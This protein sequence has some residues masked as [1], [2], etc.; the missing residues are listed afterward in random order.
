[1]QSLR[2]AWPRFVAVAI[3]MPTVVLAQ[4]R[5][6]SSLDANGGGLDTHLLRPALDSRGLLTVNGVDVLPAQGVS[7]GLTLDYGRGLLRLPQGSPSTGIVSDSFTGTFLA[8][9]G[10]GDRAVVGVSAPI[11]GMSGA[12]LD[13]Q[14]VAGVAAHAKVR[15]LRPSDGVGLAVAVQAGVPIGDAPASGGADPSAWYW[16]QL[17]LETR[18]GPSDLVRVA[19]NF[20]Y[21]G[22]ASRGTTLDL[23]GGTMQDGSRLTY[24][25]GASVRVAPPLDLVAETYGTYLL[26]G[27]SDAATRPSNE[28]LFGAKL[29]V[30]ESS[31]L[32]AG[33]GPRV[34]GGFEA[35]DVRALLGFSYEPS[36]GDRDGD[37]VRDDED[38]CPTTSGPRAHDRR[39]SGCPQD[40]DED[41]APDAED[42]CPY[43]KGPVT[44]DATTNGCPPMAPTDRDK[45]G[46]PDTIDACPGDAGKP[47]ADPTRNGC[48]DVLVGEVGLTLFDE[49]RFRTSSAELLP[50]SLPILDKVAVALNEHPQLTL[51]EVGGHA[52]ERGGERMNLALTQAR[53]DAVVA[54]LVARA[55]APER[56]QSKGY[57]FYCP[58]DPSHGE[59]AWT[60]NRRVEFL[61]V[62]TVLGATGVKRGCAAAAA[63]GVTPDPVP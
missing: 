25:G 31:F 56:L 29:F 20:G 30:E 39:K 54:A 7:F 5:T 22:H 23:R 55:V 9:Y 33:A 17:A 47:S 10:I 48:P 15:L 52:D 49:I 38:A 21:R 2:F 28:A 1:M 53:V 36:S 50:E 26:G 43:V 12:A 13:F 11:V 46:V 42:A 19:L 24:G 27:G 59:V 14:G 61:I 45:D 16:P 44:R 62:K 63:H 51:V 41:G 8:S 57:G 58:L 18:F 3:V 4:T 34:T 32:V 40:T 37:G 35:A 60:K 6:R